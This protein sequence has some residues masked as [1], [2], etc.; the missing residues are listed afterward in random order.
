LGVD[1][2]DGAEIERI[3]GGMSKLDSALSTKLGEILGIKK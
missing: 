1:P 2:V 3:V